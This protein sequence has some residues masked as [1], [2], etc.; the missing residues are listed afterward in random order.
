[1]KG[2]AFDFDGTLIDSFPLINYA[3]KVI[4]GKYGIHLDDQ[5]VHE[6]FGPSEYG[7]FKKALGPIQ[8][9]MAFQEYLEL[10]RKV[11]AQYVKPMDK[12]LIQLIKNIKDAGF[13][14]FLVTGRSPESK[15]I[16]ME[17]LGLNGLFDAEYCGSELGV[18]K[19]ESFK[20]LEKDFS[21]KRS[22]FIYVGDSKRDVKSCQEAHIR[23]ISVTYY[24]TTPAPVLYEQNPGMVV[25]TIQGLKDKLG[26]ILQLKL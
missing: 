21:L 6:L 16:S 24:R 8:G 18:N 17:V 22:D 4:F 26:E 5:T 1:M 11:H 25:E 15:A 23:L 7:A 9:R 20:K 19:A 13:L 10:Y 2:V 12:E 14:V 3:Y